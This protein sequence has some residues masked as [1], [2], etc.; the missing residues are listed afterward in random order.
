MIALYAGKRLGELI[1]PPLDEAYDFTKMLTLETMVGQDVY[2]RSFIFYVFLLEFFYIILC[3][4]KPLTA[5]FLA[6]EADKVSFNGASWPLTAALLVV[7][8]LPHTPF[9]VQ[10]EQAL[11]RFAQRM[12]QIPD[13]FY[14]RVM[15]LSN[16]EVEKIIS[17]SPRHRSDIELFYRVRNLLA[18]LDFDDEEAVRRARKCAGLRLFGAWTLRGKDLWSQ[19]EYQKYRPVLETLQPHFTELME[20]LEQ[21]VV[22]T[23][24]S[25]FVTEVV[26]QRK[27]NID[28]KFEKEFDDWRGTT[29]QKIREAG[30]DKSEMA[31]MRNDLYTKWEQLTDDC[32]V[33][34]KRHIAL[35]SI[36][37]RNDRRTLRELSRPSS[38]PML[39]AQGV[40]SRE[41]RF[42]DPALS[43][44]ATILRSNT[45][46]AE[47]WF[48]SLLT[49]SLISLV[50][51]VVAMTL[52]RLFSE[53]AF[54]H[55]AA[56]AAG[57]GHP[58]WWFF[59]GAI[60]Y[61]RTIF[62]QPSLIPSVAE[63][64]RSALFLSMKEAGAMVLAFWLA[65]AAA[66]FWRS[67][68]LADDAWL[69]FYDARTIPT[70]SYV[71]LAFIAAVGA[72]PA[73]MLQY[74][75]YYATTTCPA[76]A[77]ADALI[78]TVLTNLGVSLAIGIFA[79]GLCIITDIIHLP[80]LRDEPKFYALL[81]GAPL[82]L[83][84]F[85]L[86]ITPGYL[87]NI[88]YLANQILLFSIVTFLTAI[89]YGRLLEARS[90][91]PVM[92]F[93]SQRDNPESAGSGI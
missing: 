79:L 54:P 91:L 75:V 86:M 45:M 27:I 65:G 4:F 67:A 43:H 88:P 53:H 3:T 89:S 48:N 93:K 9:V 72:F 41:F 33:A 47:P 6:N 73:L 62:E 16:E 31:L 84:A 5:I 63:K 87:E 37:A 55:A 32:E 29:E 42:S 34:S 11:R 26:S 44:F 17:S 50:V 21:L 57:M 85:I 39:S 83:N 36:I 71:G 25:N 20:K 23:R 40:V 24:N 19:S 46:Q 82:L 81:G 90:Q 76:G 38:G 70:S 60:G 80:Q 13:D 52:F 74:V 14:N 2:R 28:L 92:I 30:G 10:I 77:C 58:V 51:S 78:G 15:A 18:L 49:A 64:V 22:D 35:F 59:M 12:A 8:V 7:G 69:T 66:L 1:S 68:K 61:F 56:S